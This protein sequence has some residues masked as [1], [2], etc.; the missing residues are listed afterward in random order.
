[1]KKLTDGWTYRR[2]VRQQTL[3]HAISSA[4]LWPGELT[5]TQEQ[6]YEIN[7]L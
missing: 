1:M 2:T 6:N 7:T 4:G 3:R 5:T